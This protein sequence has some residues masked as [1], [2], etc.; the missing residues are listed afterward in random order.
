MENTRKRQRREKAPRPAGVP[1]P[2][3]VALSQRL[4]FDTPTPPSGDVAP[5]AMRDRENMFTLFWGPSSLSVIFFGRVFP[6]RGI[7]PVQCLSLTCSA[8][9]RVY[10]DAKFQR[11]L[12]AMTNRKARHLIE[13]IESHTADFHNVAASV[14]LRQSTHDHVRVSNCLHLSICAAIHFTICIKRLLQLTFLL[15]KYGN[16]Q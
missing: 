14:W 11:F 13:Q 9:S 7:L 15:K 2:V 10:S 3:S 8:R 6:A 12:R 16:S 5:L 4:V 1:H